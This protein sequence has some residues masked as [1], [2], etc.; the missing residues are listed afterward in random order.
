[1]ADIAEFLD[2]ARKLKST[3][4]TGWIERGVREPESSA[5]HSWMMGLM[6]LTLPFDGDRD[7]ALRMIAV[8]DL[9]E[10]V[11][12][13]I[14]SKDNW[15][16]GSHTREEKTRLE[17][18]AMKGII[19]KLDRSTASE[20]M[21]LWTEFNE[22]KTKEAVF[23]RDIDVAERLI[24][25]LAYRKEGNFRKPLDGFWDETSLSKIKS[26]SIKAL[27]KKIIDKG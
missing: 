27:V 1:M 7:R 16:A 19:A 22:G 24:Q 4:R 25:A 17:R 5:D 9:A 26:E 3:K 12:G 6:A 18:D 10:A 2:V 23:A 11:V 13:D 14:I 8:H 21:K 20:M 15:N